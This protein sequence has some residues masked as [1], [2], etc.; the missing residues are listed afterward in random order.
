MLDTLRADD[1]GDDDGGGSGWALDARRLL[2]KEG[3]SPL[4]ESTMGF[5]TSEGGG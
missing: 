2:V 3:T 5:A 1:D 4:G